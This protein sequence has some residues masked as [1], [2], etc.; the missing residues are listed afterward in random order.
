MPHLPLGVVQA[1]SSISKNKPDCPEDF[2]REQMETLQIKDRRH[3]QATEKWR[4][5]LA[6]SRRRVQGEL[7][8]PLLAHMLDELGVGEQESVRQWTHSDS[9]LPSG[10]G[11]LPNAELT[12]RQLPANSKWGIK[13]RRAAVT[14]PQEAALRE[15]AP[16]Q[17]DVG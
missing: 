6:D 16:N 3:Q 14:E 12:P 2:G 9:G 1:V 5:S 8:L 15:D 17:V 11:G 10:T 4:S 7:S 13:A